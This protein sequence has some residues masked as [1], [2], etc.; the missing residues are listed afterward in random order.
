MDE[1]IIANLEKDLT[2]EL[3]PAFSEYLAI[4]TGSQGDCQGDNVDHIEQA[5]LE[6]GVEEIP[7]PIL[8][9]ITLLNSKPDNAVEIADIIIE[10]QGISSYLGT[11]YARA[12]NQISKMMYYAM[13]E[14][15]TIKDKSSKAEAVC[16]P[17]K[18]VRDI[19]RYLFLASFR[20]RSELQSLL[21]LEKEEFSKF[22][23]E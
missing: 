16:A 17:Y 15:G 18:A 9:A 20:A 7:S 6:I 23:S 10:W 21:K 13:P 1:N 11:L 19:I 5:F 22:R 8:D 12:N 2:Q 4:F 3:E 14:D